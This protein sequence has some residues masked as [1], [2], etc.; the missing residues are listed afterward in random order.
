VRKRRERVKRAGKKKI[1]KWKVKN[2][3]KIKKALYQHKNTPRFHLGVF[4]CILAYTLWSI[5]ITIR[6]IN[7]A[8]IIE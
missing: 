2:R 8:M 6:L 3:G 1:K 5:K 7:R 4:W